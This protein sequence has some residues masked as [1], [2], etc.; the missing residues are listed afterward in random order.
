MDFD[1][2]ITKKRSL[3]A[4]RRA[5]KTKPRSPDLIGQ[6]RLQRHTIKA[7]VKQCQETES[8]EIICNMAGW[9]NHDHSGQYL[10]VEL[11]SRYPSKQ[12]DIPKANNLNFVFNDE[13][14]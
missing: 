9:S 11:S 1:E 8:E 7:I 10:T 5:P 4:L 6:L 14:E 2:P 12:Q 3:G 13:E